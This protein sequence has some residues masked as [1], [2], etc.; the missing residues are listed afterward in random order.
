METREEIFRVADERDV[1]VIAEHRRHMFEE[2]GMDF[3]DGDAPFRS[4]LAERLSTGAYRGWIV[5]HGARPVGGVGMMILDWPP[6]PRHVQDDRRGYILNL[7]VEPAYRRRG[8]AAELM[9]R[10]YAHARGLHIAYLTLHASTMGRPL[11]ERDGWSGTNE[12][13]ISLAR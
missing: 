6:H 4:W 8:I 2:A 9:E 5:S 10:C 13:S 7:Y 11:Y 1:D 12:M 3:S